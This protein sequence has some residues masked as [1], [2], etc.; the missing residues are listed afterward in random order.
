MARP[1][2]V[3][4]LQWAYI[5]RSLV[6]D[7]NYR[8]LPKAWLWFINLPKGKEKKS[9]GGKEEKMKMKKGKRKKRKE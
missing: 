7:D 3:G 2:K 1:R 6:V 4:D 8:I 9:G 5:L